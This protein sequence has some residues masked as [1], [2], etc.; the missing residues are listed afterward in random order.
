MKFAT[1]LLLVLFAL[2]ASCQ[3][4]FQARQ[5]VTTIPCPLSSNQELVWKFDHKSIK[6]IQS[7]INKVIENFRVRK[8]VELVD[9][10]HIYALQYSLNHTQDEAYILVYS[11]T[12]HRWI[13]V[14]TRKLFLDNDD[15]FYPI[16]QDKIASK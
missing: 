7:G 2:A 3:S 12:R 15:R 5:S 9:N 1:T 10:N 11:K 14:T 16:R 4:N 6:V 8:V 13:A